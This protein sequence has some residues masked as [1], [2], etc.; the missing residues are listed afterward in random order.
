MGVI[1]G[2]IPKVLINTLAVRRSVLFCNVSGR[3]LAPISQAMFLAFSKSFLEHQTLL[4]SLEPFSFAKE[5][6]SPV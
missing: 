4:E 1:K 5:L 2:Y 6:L 3:M